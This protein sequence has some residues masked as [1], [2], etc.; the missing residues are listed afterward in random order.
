M[1][2]QRL[3][4]ESSEWCRLTDLNE[5]MKSVFNSHCTA[6]APANFMK[7]TY[8]CIAKTHRSA[9]T[10]LAITVLG[11]HRTTYHSPLTTRL[12]PFY[13]PSNTISSTRPLTLHPL[14]PQ[15]LV[16][17]ITTWLPSQKVLQSLHLFLRSTL[18]KHH[19]SVSPALFLVH[20]IL[21]EH[22]VEHIH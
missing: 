3:S 9:L 15:F 21:L 13:S 14:Q 16:K 6:T 10:H 12:H 17:R 20:W 7:A 5:A 22:T 11:T 1:D 8:V 4:F 19:M 18:L 2:N